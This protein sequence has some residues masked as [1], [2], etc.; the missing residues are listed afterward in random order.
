MG[1][2]YTRL[3][4]IFPPPRAHSNILLFED[5]SGA[6]NWE[7]SSS[8]SGGKA[9][10]DIS[11]TLI[12]PMSCKLTTDSATPGAG[13]NAEIQQVLYTLDT[14]VILFDILF[15]ITSA[16]A[17]G[18]FYIMI[19]AYTDSRYIELQFRVD[20]TNGNVQYMNSSGSFVTPSGLTFS[21]ILPKWYRFKGGFNLSTEKYIF[22]QLDNKKADIST[23]S[24]QGEDNV[25]GAVIYFKLYIDIPST[26][27]GDIVFNQILLTTQ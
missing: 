18:N 23:I 9:I 4:S 7:F 16:N 10:K 17:P 11:Q 21:K 24:T 27:R 14:E 25:D 2:E 12:N 3:S 13:D 5:F 26:N 15:Y 22:I 19:D 1:K 8:P 20:F 6:L